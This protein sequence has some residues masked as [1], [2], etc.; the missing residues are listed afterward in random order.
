[1]AEVTVSDLAKSVGASVERLLGQM[2]DAGLKQTSA[3][4]VV[5]DEE[6]KALLTSLKASHG[7]DT[8]APRKI[9]LK[10]KTTSTLKVGSGSARKTVNVEV[11]KKRTYIKRDV[12]TEEPIEQAELEPEIIEQPE[13]E[14]EPVPAPVEEIIEEVIEEPAV[15]AEEKEETKAKPKVRFDAIEEK[16]LAAIAA[17]RKQENLAQ[18]SMGLKSQ[19]RKSSIALKLQKV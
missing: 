18:I 7:E 4:D 13:I 15:A 2:K 12:E 10:R 16:R 3:D 1:M 17:R 14:K 9:T 11:R 19:R 5:S 8:D 6:K